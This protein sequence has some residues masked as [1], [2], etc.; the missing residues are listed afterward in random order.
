MDT[1]DVMNMVDSRYIVTVDDGEGGGF[2]VEAHADKDEAEHI[3]CS[4]WEFY[5]QDYPDMVAKVIDLAT[6][7]TVF[8]TE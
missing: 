7:E 1:Y 5:E 8:E 3:A 2:F 6:M 4:A